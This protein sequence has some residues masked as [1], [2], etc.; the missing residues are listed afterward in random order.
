MSEYWIDIE[1]SSGTRYGDGPIMTA[2]SWTFTSHRNKIGSFSFSMPIGDPRAQYLIPFRIV[3]CWQMLDGKLISRGAGRIK[4][5]TTS[6]G[7]AGVLTVTGTD[8]LGE[9]AWATVGDLNIY[10]DSWLHAARVV[11]VQDAVSTTKPYACDFQVNDTTTST[12]IFLIRGDL[13]GDSYFSVWS[14]FT[15]DSVHFI[16]DGTV[17]QYADMIEVRY[18]DGETESWETTDV[19]EDTTGDDGEMFT[20]TGTITINPPGTWSIE[21]GVSAYEL[22]FANIGSHNTET[23]MCS[24]ISV[25]VK[26]ETSSALEIVSPFL[27][28]G[29]SLD[30]AN[31][32]TEIGPRTDFGNELLTNTSFETFTGTADDGSSNTFTDWGNVGVDDPSGNKIE[33]VT[34][35]A[36]SGTH[37]VKLSAGTSY[38]VYLAREID[39][40]DNQDITVSFWTGAGGTGQAALSLYDPLHGGY[41][42]TNA[43]DSGITGSEWEEFTATI[44]MP[45]GGTKLGIAILCPITLGTHCYV[46]DVSVRYGGGGSV[47]LEQHGESVFETLE[48]IAEQTGENFTGGYSDRSILWLQDEARDT[49]LHA[50]IVDNPILA[51]DNDDIVLIMNGNLR[52]DCTNL[53][54]RIYP[55]GGGDGDDR[56]TLAHCTR[57]VPSGYTLDKDNNYLERTDAST[58]YDAVIETH[59]TFSDVIALNASETQQQRA[60]NMLFDLAYEH[61]RKHSC[62]DLDRTSGSYDVPRFANVTV[63]KCMR[64]LWPGHT[65]HCLYD[66]WI[67][68]YHADHLDEN[69]WINSRTQ[70]LNAEGEYTETLELASIDRSQKTDG[71]WVYGW[72]KDVKR[73]WTRRSIR[74]ADGIYSSLIVKDGTIIGGY[75]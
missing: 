13:G 17:S 2:R 14:M 19:V 28:D 74:V 30:A 60:S 44:T 22:R 25:K 51:N 59:K 63:A 70:N 35:V 62:T 68:G 50:V 57:T 72:I 3:R 42:F 18:Y 9:L 7:D 47:M 1:D 55:Y 16:M 27:P 56:A 31:G 5:I 66:K 34:T 67:D 15:F 61:L 46:D 20:H 12:S 29:W 49:T 45:E 26:I 40:L 10:D 53:I 38:N 24:D 71:E 23:F 69:M 41:P 6:T 52:H 58:A 4:S 37:A 54:S 75:A 36:H 73:S 11:L 64:P 8:L 39:V 21:P 65:V 48:S 33:A 32:Y 43:M